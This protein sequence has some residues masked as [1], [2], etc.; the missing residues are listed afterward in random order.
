MSGGGSQGRQNAGLGAGRRRD[1]SWRL[2]GKALSARRAWP[3]MLVLLP[4]LSERFQFCGCFHFRRQSKYPSEEMHRFSTDDNS[5]ISKTILR[6][7]KDF[8]SRSPALE[9]EG[10]GYIFS[11]Y[12]AKLMVDFVFS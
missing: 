2:H 7:P 3:R 5:I 12:N 4:I 8:S 6:K 10:P 11:L 1:L 9:A